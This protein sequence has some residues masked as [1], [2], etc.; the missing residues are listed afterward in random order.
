MVGV[1]NNQ[2]NNQGKNGA[3]LPLQRK[4]PILDRAQRYHWRLL[5]HLFVS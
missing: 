2:E 3:G 1:E 5:R 4:L